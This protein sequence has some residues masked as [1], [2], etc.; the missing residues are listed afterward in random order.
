MTTNYIYLL[1]EREFIKTKENIFKVGMTKKENHK[2]FNQYPTGSILLFQ[3]VCNDCKSNER[4]IIQKFKETFIQRKDIG[5]EYFEGDYISMIDI[6][7]L[8]I[9]NENTNINEEVTIEE[10]DENNMDYT[11]YVQ[12]VKNKKYQEDAFKKICNNIINSIF[13]DYRN[14][15]EFGGE[16]K[17]FKITFDNDE[18]QYVI[19]YI[20][21]QLKSL[22]YSKDG[23]VLIGKDYYENFTEHECTFNLLY[24]T[25]CEDHINFGGIDE[26]K[27]FDTL[28]RDKIIIPNTI[29]DLCSTNFVKKLL[30][31]KMQIN[32]ENHDEF[33]LLHNNTFN[34]SVYSN[35]Y[36]F[37]CHNLVINKKIYGSVDN[38]IADKIK[39]IDSFDNFFVDI[40]GNR[41]FK[42][43]TLFKIK[44]NYYDFDSFLRKYTP[45]LMRWDTNNNYYI[46]NRD[47]EYIGLNCKNIEYECEG[48]K[49]LFKDDSQPWNSRNDYQNMINEYKNCIRH[50]RLNS[51]LNLHNST[52]IILELFDK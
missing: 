2:R 7:Y 31:T 32:I 11:D 48:H 22:L 20:N 41:D 1:Q 21:P 43:I 18:D 16:S 13:P 30:K 40:G 47:C 6:I 28:I 46:L 33:I 15:R 49:Y 50:N 37:L 38:N 34:N 26:K 51:C 36:S 5:S 29:Y 4:V 17:F 12:Y 25:I 42:L 8:T 9:K 35:I 14:D 10:I 23:F 19:H 45:Y 44:T 39:K 52:K 24:K 3:M 27:Y